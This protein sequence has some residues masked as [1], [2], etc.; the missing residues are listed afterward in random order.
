M[1]HFYLLMAL[2]FTFS[3]KAQQSLFNVPS[4]E[5]TK[6]KGFFLQEQLNFNEQIQSNLTLVWGLGKDWEVGCNLLGIDYSFP[7]QG[8]VSN[9]EIEG[10]PFAPLLL[11]NVQK[12]FKLSERFKIGLGTQNGINVTDIKQPQY[13]NF[14][15]ANLV[16]SFHE[17]ALKIITGMYYGNSR[18]LGE[19]NSYGPMLGIEAS[20]IHNKLSLMADWIH[21]NHD[22]GVSVFGIVW[23]P[24]KRLPLSLGWQKPNSNNGNSDA[25]VLEI[26]LLPK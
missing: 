17:D 14:S 6:A 11:V 20:I 24:I 16:T 15:F 22:L 8:F 5:I 2:A 25:F 12:G 18:Y 1:R 3:V 4:S 13:V 26:T 10:D 19:N 23:Y 7:K 21:G 9:D